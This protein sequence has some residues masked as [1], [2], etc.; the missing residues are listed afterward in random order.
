LTKQVHRLRFIASGGVL[1]NVLREADESDEDL[2]LAED[3]D[4]GEPELF[5][6][7]QRH[8]RRYAKR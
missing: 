4:G 2:M 5:F 6:D 3:G 1:K 8:I 7:W